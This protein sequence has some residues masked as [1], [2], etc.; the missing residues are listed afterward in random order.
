MSH[1]ADDMLAT[2]NV[3]LRDRVCELERRVGE[4]EDELVLLR[5]S[6]AD[7]LRRLKQI[8]VV[9]NG[10]TVNNRTITGR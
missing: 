6:M 5:S 8:E 3:T 4:Q 9:E 7:V 1:F 2:E 10:A